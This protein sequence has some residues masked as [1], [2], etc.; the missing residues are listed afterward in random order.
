MRYLGGKARIAKKLTSFLQ[1][2][3]KEGQPYAEPFVGGGSVLRLING[4]RFASDLSEDLILFY[5]EMQNGW[6]PPETLSEEKYRQ[7]KT[8]HPSGL[9]GFAGF[10]CSFGGKWFGGYARDPK[11][12]RSFPK[13]AHTDALRLASQTVDVEFSCLHY[14]EFLEIIPRGSFVYCDPP[15]KG[16]TG[17]KNKFNHTFFWEQ[18]R[19][20]S[21][22]HDI[23]ISEYKAPDDFECV[24]SIERKTE[25]NTK[26]GKALRIEKLFRYKGASNG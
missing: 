3:R 12:N 1:S 23:L 7:L 18:M 2:W 21:N 17:Y 24:W 20:W 4:E 8:M 6:K 26:D 15:Y 22:V 25:L 5:K 10:F 13:E 9:R 11:T 19:M 14:S 16:T